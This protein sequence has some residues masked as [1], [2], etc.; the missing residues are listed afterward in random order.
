MQRQL[1][2][3]EVALQ[4]REA[5]ARHA[6]GRL[7][8]DQLARQLEVVARL[9][10]ARGRRR[11]RAASSSSSAADRIG[12]V[13][14]R[15]RSTPSSA[16][17]TDGELLRQRLRPAARPPASRRSRRPRPARLLGARDRLRGLVL[18]RPQPLDLG[19]Q[20]APPRVE[21]QRLV[22]PRVRAVAAPR[23]RRAHGV[24]VPPD[25]L[26]VE[27]GAA[28]AKRS[29]GRLPVPEYFAMKSRDRLGLL[30]DHDVLRHRAGGEAAVADRVEDLVLYSSLRWSKF[31]PSLYSRLLA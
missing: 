6:R 17:S 30:A 9:V 15:A 21:R 29:S 14:E 18:A 16:A 25:R 22:Q 1:E 26:Q 19:Q 27:H 10:D 12:R 3:H 2:Q 7:H 20:L 31:G 8:V 24:R 11:P 5:R 4:V 23:Q 28:T 13:R